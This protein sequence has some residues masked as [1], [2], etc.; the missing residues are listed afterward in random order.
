MEEKLNRLYLECINELNSIGIDVLDKE[1]IGKINIDISN[2][3]TKAYGYC[4][5]EE[6]D[7]KY[8]S[9]KIYNYKRIVTYQ[10][11]KVHNI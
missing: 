11:F 8:K 2:R 9:I 1:I 4:K 10:K 7:K 5:Q 6:P 3:S